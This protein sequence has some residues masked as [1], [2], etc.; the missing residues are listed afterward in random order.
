M[1]RVYRF[2]GS[3]E[4]GL[5]LFVLIVECLHFPVINVVTLAVSTS[6]WRKS[7]ELSIY[8]N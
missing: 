7:S 4:N 1:A 2:E 5:A 3:G 8:L 6:Y